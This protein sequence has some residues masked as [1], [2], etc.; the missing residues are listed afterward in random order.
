MNSINDFE[1]YSNEE[2]CGIKNNIL[3]FSGP[4]YA[5][6]GILLGIGAYTNTWYVILIAC[7]L[8]GIF[9]SLQISVNDTNNKYAKKTSSRMVRFISY[10][11]IFFLFVLLR[12]FPEI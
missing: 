11:A 10:I 3:R 6:S 9:E 2:K 12:L 7:M 8:L 4:W 1:I 5:I